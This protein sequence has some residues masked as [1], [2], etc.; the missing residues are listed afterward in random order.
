VAEFKLDWDKEVSGQMRCPG[1]YQKPSQCKLISF[2]L[3]KIL[4]LPLYYL[5]CPTFYFLYGQKK[6][7][8]VSCRRPGCGCLMSW[9]ILPIILVYIGLC[10]G[11][12]LLVFSLIPGYIFLFIRL[13]RLCTANSR[14][15]YC[16]VGCCKET[17]Y[18]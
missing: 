2:T 5:L 7:M 17:R 4:F 15:S 11:I 1:Y 10:F 12:M 8:L 6:D 14:K 13:T 16:A 18:H 9:T 3:L